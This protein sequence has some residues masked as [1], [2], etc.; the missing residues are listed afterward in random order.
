MRARMISLLVL[1]ALA[2]VVPASAEDLAARGWVK[3]QDNPEIWKD[4]NTNPVKYY[5]K[6]G[7]AMESDGKGGYTLAQNQPMTFTSQSG[8]TG[9]LQMDTMPDGRSKFLL[10]EDNDQAKVTEHSVAYNND[11]LVGTGAVTQDQANGINRNVTW[12]L[13]DQ[14]GN[15]MNEQQGQNTAY[16]PTLTEP[17]LYNLSN[18]GV[19]DVPP[20]ND[21]VIGSGTYTQGTSPPANLTAG[22]TFTTGQNSELEVVDVTAPPQG[23]VAFIPENT[24]DRNEIVLAAGSEID[25]Y[26]MTDKKADLSVAGKNFSYQGAVH[27]DTA[28]PL[29]KTVAIPYGTPAVPDQFKDKGVT[30]SDV[31]NGR[32]EVWLRSDNKVDFDQATQIAGPIFPAGVRTRFEVGPFA[33]N[34]KKPQPVKKTWW[35]TIKR[36]GKEEK[37]TEPADYIFPVPN[38]AEDGKIAGAPEY[39]FTYQFWDVAGN[40]TTV[41]VDMLA[42][43]MDVKVQDL[44]S[45][46]GRGD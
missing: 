36:D 41:D 28:N 24:F 26:P 16:T 37:L 22:G 43:K 46:Q 1:L 40:R 44:D 42:A 15:L 34:G 35:L 27:P 45:K 7:L 31:G 8:E 29:T 2:W 32:K 10:Q 20:N 18:S 33:D 30:P 6:D 4:P 38:Y 12:Q 9:D 5:S 13:R 39:V 17:G 14:D 23:K 19:S 21:V 3:V 11:A 25:Q